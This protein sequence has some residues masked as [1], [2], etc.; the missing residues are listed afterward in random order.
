MGLRRL[1]H[2]NAHCPRL[3]LAVTDATHQDGAA[4]YRGCVLC[5]FGTLHDGVL[6]CTNPV[7]ADPNPLPATVARQPGAV[8]GPDAAHMFWVFEGALVCA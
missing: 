2:G 7:V 5:S 6:M 1:V 3:G 8:C 4:G